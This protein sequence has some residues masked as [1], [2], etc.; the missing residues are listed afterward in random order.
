MLTDWVNAGGTL[1]ALRPDAQ[2]ST[3]LG[4][5]PAAGTLDNK[6]LLVNT[7]SGPGVGIVNQTIQYH[8][9]A[10]LYTLS[11]ATAVATLYSDATTSTPNPA[12]TTRGVGS[13]GGR[14]IA[15]TY[16]LARSIVYTRQGNPAWA[17]QKRDGQIEPIRP[18]DM[19]FGNAAGDPQPDWIDLNKV[20]IPQADEQQR[21][22]ANAITLGNLHRM[23]LPRLWYL[24]KG[25]KAAIVMT[26]DN[27]ADTGM[28]PRFE[29][30]RN[31]STPGC[32]VEDWDCIRATGYLYVGSAFTPAQ[33]QMYEN[34]GFEVAIHINSGC[35]R[36]TRESYD[37]IATSELANFAA[38]LPGVS[39]PV[40][41]RNHC[42]Q[43]TDWT[44]TPEVELAHGIR[45][46]TNYYYWP[47]TWIQNRP[48]M[49]SGSG[50]PMRFAKQDGSIIDCYQAVTEMPD[51][52]GESFPAFCDALLD[53]ANGPEGYYGVFTTNM[54]FDYVPEPSSD[55]IV[56]SAQAHGVPVVSA[57]QMLTWLDGR[58]GSNFADLAWSGNQL[59]FN[60]TV[61]SGAR[62]LRGMLPVLAAV[63][64]LASLTRNGNPV[65][66]T[67]QV[68]K[69]VDYAFFPADAG[70]YVATYLV[71]ETPPVISAVTGT[72]LTPT[73][74]R[75]Q[76]TTDEPSNSHVDYGTSPG[77][78]TLSLETSTLTTSHSVTLTALA[79]GTTYHYRV[80][81]TDDVSN[82]A[83]SPAS[84]A[85]PASFSTSTAPCA[86]DQTAADFAQGSTAGG[87]AI[88][89]TGDGEVTLAPLLSEDFNGNAL[90]AGWGSTPWIGGGTATVSGGAL[91]VSGSAAYGLST[92]PPGHSI[93]FVATYTASPYQNVGLAAASDGSLGGTWVLIGMGGSANGVYAR[94]SN[95]VDILLSTATLGTPHL[96]RIDWNANDFTFFIDGVQAGVMPFAVATPMLQIVSDYTLDANVLS[97]DWLRVLPFTTS[98]NFTSRVFDGGSLGSW[99]AASWNATTP[100]GTSLS[101]FQR[102]G[103]T[104]V[105]DGSWSAFAAISSNGAVVGGSSRYLQYR[106]DLSSNT[107]LATP[108]LD[109]VQI[110]CSSSA[111]VTPPIISSVLATPGAGGT[112]AQVTWTTNELS[113][114]SIDYGT[115]PG[116][117]GS[118][119]SVSTLAV[120]HALNLVSLTPST[121]YYYRVSSADAASNSATFPESP[122][123]P[124]SFTTPAP[125]PS[126][127]AQDQTAANFSAGTLANT[128]VTTTGDG[129]V[130]L[131]PS[132]SVDF[133]DNALPAGWSSYDWPFDGPVSVPTF[134][135][136]VMTIDGDRASPEPFATGPGSTLEFVATCSG[137]SFQHV[138]FGA[139]NHLPPNEIFNTLPFV[140]FSTAGG[141]AVEAHT[142]TG[143][144]TE[145][146]VVPGEFRGA[147]HRYRIDWKLGSV[148]FW[149]DGVLVHTAAVAVPGPMR[150]AASDLFADGS[151]VTLDWMTLTP[152]VTSGTFA[153][154]VFDAGSSVTWAAMS[155]NALTPAGTS[156][157]FQVRKG[158]TPV[159]DGTWTAYAPVA[160]SGAS[161]GGLSRYL[162]YSVAFATSDATV[163]PVLQDVTVSCSA[164]SGGSTAIADLSVTRAASG[165]TAGRLPLTIAFTQPV[166]ATSVK[167]YRAPFGGYPRYDD[168]G[169]STPSTPSYPPGAAWTLTSV[170]ASGQQDDPGARDQWHYVA[171]WQNSCG[172]YSAASNRPAGVLD[173]IL[174]DV[175]DGATVCAGDNAV[176]TGDLSVLGAHYGVTLTGAEAYV[177]ADVGPTTDASPNGRPTTDGL[178][179]FEDL[180]IFALDYGSS[181]G[182]GGALVAGTAQA[183][184]LSAASRDELQLDAPGMVH[185]G[186]TFTVTLRMGGAGGLR[187]VSV[188]RPGRGRR[189]AAR[190][191]SGGFLGPDGIALSPRPEWWMAPCSASARRGSRATACWR[192]SRSWRSGRLADAGCGRGGRQGSPEPEVTLGGTLAARSRC[193]RSPRSSASRRTRS[194]TGRRWASRWRARAR[195]SCRS[196]RSTVGWC[197]RWRAGRCRRAG[198]RGVGPSQQPWRP[199]RVGL[200]IVR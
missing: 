159:P 15:F 60:M 13:N 42:L 169:G 132:L 24:P 86:Q 19:F 21:L 1:V 195:S 70:G 105:P 173:Y 168:A 4:I 91:T 154:R 25:L 96:Y 22:L 72:P 186:E 161:V 77:S 5:T 171:F 31:Q 82:T 66:F 80:S 97:V 141:G 164:C 150:P 89:Q 109:D 94:N 113:N 120:S 125:P 176:G 55:A 10:D 32:S 114:S 165:G 92:F 62:N 170:T 67:R 118:S 49:F 188:P 172:A 136:G 162:Q 29:I 47:A 119:L 147:P 41:N 3:L 128:V 79:S 117:L 174:G 192:R 43:W 198:T 129:E 65:A 115:S 14:A 121:T 57:K 33:A 187:G 142:Y 175:S 102:Q 100:A 27:H 59:S 83:T 2:L 126:T 178:L 12:V 98:G 88:T 163:T 81:S 144:G 76:W 182:G 124:L 108:V 23:P 63:G 133:S 196:T 157:A 69:G 197:G 191:P 137:G 131:A 45:F 149:I 184:K 93:E 50:M 16:D 85:A 110:Q 153:S 193:R 101:M 111:D 143:S 155:W 116:T 122:A 140:I 54:H 61:G 17:G 194:A 160:S 36:Q 104:P 51:E 34:L 95:N 103:S 134:S 181:G 87:T 7:A 135:G 58:N 75:I 112:T 18:D 180:L 156:L 40:T 28:A 37:A 166:G 48:G 44:A 20:A 71:D 199:G 151:V 200:Y 152:Y 74:A 68:I 177:C 52:S 190:R 179:E 99:G 130:T 6:Y 146:F 30:Y 185:A 46:D 11:G 148:D 84:P 145:D 90:P 26:G 106:A 73:S 139:C 107:G 183:A 123:A 38:A 189:H 127:C 78:L 39:P 158:D 56:A 167:V 35:A 9:S 53:R 64:E 138:G 8:G